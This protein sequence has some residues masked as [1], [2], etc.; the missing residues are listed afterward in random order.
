MKNYTT[1]AR[2]AIGFAIACIAFG[3]ATIGVS[4]THYVGCCIP[5]GVCDLDKLSA[6]SVSP[7]NQRQTYRYGNGLC[8]FSDSQIQTMQCNVT[9]IG[10]LS[11]C[12]TTNAD[13]CSEGN[14][15]SDLLTACGALLIS[16]AAIIGMALAWN[17][18]FE[19]DNVPRI[20]TAIVLA[21][22]VAVVIISAVVIAS[23]RER[24]LEVGPAEGKGGCANNNA[25]SRTAVR[26]RTFHTTATNKCF[27]PSVSFMCGA[28][29]PGG[30]PLRLERFDEHS[31]LAMLVFT[32]L[33]AGIGLV[34]SAVLS[35]IGFSE[36]SDDDDDSGDAAAVTPV[37]TASGDDKDAPPTNCGDDDTAGDVSIEMDEKHSA[38]HHHPDHDPHNGVVANS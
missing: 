21:A 8:R 1:T 9:A 23:W 6:G 2:I 35:I 15:T 10:I 26:R 34:G 7:S 18:F 27:S 14:Q 28:H 25:A 13:V 5:N 22:S 31:N 33:L 24:A 20:P 32:L 3:S 4:S 30:D 36:K 17:R 11:Y 29:Q 38:D 12:D 16:I 37:S 19:Q